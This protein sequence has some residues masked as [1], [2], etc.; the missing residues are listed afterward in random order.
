MDHQYMRIYQGLQR[1][2]LITPGVILFFFGRTLFATGA[3]KKAPCPPLFS[4]VVLVY[5]LLLCFL[6]T[7]CTSVFSFWDLTLV[8]T[9]DSISYPDKTIELIIGVL[10][11]DR[12][13]PN[14]QPC[15][16]ILTLQDLYFPGKKIISLTKNF[17]TGKKICSKMEFASDI[18]WWV[19]QKLFYCKF[20]WLSRSGALTQG[21]SF[22]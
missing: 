13:G 22:Y 4:V 2:P 7:F 5:L 8:D 16:N 14:L 10:I 3:Y 11:T 19:P 9:V 17:F 6:L 18:H 12:V 1:D 15:W 21:S 20:P